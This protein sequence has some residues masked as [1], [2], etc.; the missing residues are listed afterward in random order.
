MKGR[1]AFLVVAA[2]PWAAAAA[3]W[4]ASGDFDSC[5][6]ASASWSEDLEREDASRCA[7]AVR[8]LLQESRSAVDHERVWAVFDRL[9]AGSH[10][11]RAAFG[12][13]LQRYLERV[14]DDLPVPARERPE[15][16]V[17]AETELGLARA[18]YRQLAA[19]YDAVGGAPCDQHPPDGEDERELEEVIVGYLRGRTTA[20]QTFAVLAHLRCH[21]PMPGRE[22]GPSLAAVATELKRYE[23]A[24]GALLEWQ[25]LSLLQPDRPCQRLV[26]AAGH[27]WERVTLG[28]WLE[29]RS[30]ALFS[31]A[32]HGSA[33]LPALLLAAAP[34]AEFPYGTGA[35]AQVA[36]RASL[37]WALALFVRRSGP[38]AG[39]DRVLRLVGMERD[40][41]PAPPPVQNGILELLADNVD[42]HVGFNVADTASHLLTDLCR[43]ESLPA[44]RVMVRSPFTTI[45]Q[46]GAL[47]LAALGETAPEI[48]PD[49]PVSFGITVDGLPLREWEVRWEVRGGT[50]GWPLHANGRA[51]TD[52]HGVVLVDRDP[53]L[54]TKAPA[55]AVSVE[56][57]GFKTAK[58]L[59]FVATIDAPEDLDRPSTV[60]IQTQS[61]TVECDSTR[62]RRILLQASW[63]ARGH[64]RYPRSIAGL[65]FVGGSTT[66]SRLQ[67][68]PA[69]RVVLSGADGWSWTSEE[70]TLGGAPVALD[71]ARPAPSR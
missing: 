64:R 50:E 20:E 33:R 39:Y 60:G 43:A 65:P 30:D 68:G 29:G 47:G 8:Q 14:T 26:A 28:G 9:P 13:L 4:A 63:D 56:T 59:W 12:A 48:H 3:A 46:R 62:A 71:C 42:P 57:S 51:Q 61:L 31:L 16:A 11:R 22:F 5:E 10:F 45:R 69:Y 40:G 19:A 1:L 2:C 38:C 53:F 67:Q 17:D 52:A 32:R 41:E 25:A 35:N 58:D 21:R 34:G 54:D 7:I 18:E 44:F 6:R 55:A 23:I 36:G 27:D 37:M 49:G 70:V 66:F 24:A 15:A